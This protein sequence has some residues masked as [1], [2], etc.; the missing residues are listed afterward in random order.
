MACSVSTLE[1]PTEWVLVEKASPDTAFLAKRVQI[2]TT[3]YTASIPQQRRAERPSLVL[4]PTEMAWSER[5][6][7]RATAACSAKATHK[8]APARPASAILA[9][10]FTATAHTE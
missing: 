4:A 9:S 10:A 2:C 7:K 1:P 3:E 8:T 5:M 6:T